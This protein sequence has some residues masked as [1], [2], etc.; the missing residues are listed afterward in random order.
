MEKI[1]QDISNSYWWLSVVI[2]GILINIISSFI[3]KYYE[4]IGSRLSDK[5][6][7]KYEAEIKLRNDT[8]QKINTDKSF[9]TKYLFEIINLKVNAIRYLIIG[10]IYFSAPIDLLEYFASTFNWRQGFDIVWAIYFIISVFGVITIFLAY[11]I[12]KSALKQE[13][14]Y[15]E[16]QNH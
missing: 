11:R 9:E 16:S 8:I 1:I 2:V 3:F 7:K 12:L 15:S 14:I 13:S 5:K 4:Q 10:L 6:R